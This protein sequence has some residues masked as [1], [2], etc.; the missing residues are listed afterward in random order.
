MDAVTALAMNLLITI[1]LFQISA[2]PSPAIL[3]DALQVHR[4]GISGMMGGATSQPERRPFPI[5]RYLAVACMLQELPERE[6]VT[7]LR[8]AAANAHLAEPSVYLARMLIEKRETDLRGIYAYVGGHAA[9]KT[10]KEFPDKPLEIFD[11]V[12]FLVATD[13]GGTGYPENPADYMEY[14]LQNGKWRSTKFILRTNKEIEIVAQKYF[15]E[16]KRQG[17]SF[18]ATFEKTISE[19]CAVPLPTSNKP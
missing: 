2:G 13:A 6:R 1:L 14:M 9:G 19:Q 10:D 8:M 17:L 15:E 12:P 7:W 11:G 16:L 4:Y 5:S 18:D 3:G